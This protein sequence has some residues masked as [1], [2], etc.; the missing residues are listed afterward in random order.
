M[1]D[2]DQNTQ[3][4]VTPN[5][6]PKPKRKKRAKVE[7]DVEAEAPP[8]Q[9]AGKPVELVKQNPGEI[10]ATFIRMY[11]PTLWCLEGEWMAYTAGAYLSITEKTV[12]ARVHKFLAKARQIIVKKDENGN[13][14][15]TTGPFNPKK[16]D[17]NEVMEA[18]TL[19]R[20]L[21]IAQF[22]P[23]CWLSKKDAD[24]NPRPDPRD[25][26]V[27]KNGLLNIR[28]RKLL[29]HTASFFTRTALPIE[30]KEDAP[31]P[32]GWLKFL[33]EVTKKRAGLVT[34]VQE[35]CGYL[36]SSD[37]EQEKVFYMVGKSRGG[38]GTI[39]ESGDR[40]ARPQQ[41]RRSYHPQLLR[42]LLGVGADGQI[43]CD[44]DRYD[45]NGQAGCEDR[46]LQYQHAERARPGGRGSQ[47]PPGTDRNVP[48]NSLRPNR[49]WAPGLW[50]AHDRAGEPLVGHSV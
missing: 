1:S 45:H 30:Y 46:R 8:K 24:G 19:S 12:R 25:I 18:L 26:I 37:A 5:P 36:T 27:C 44:G 48:P 50:R 21:P 9:E 47:V 34:L 49:Q 20:H 10:A 11:A 4:T 28:T 43:G 15:Q 2:E 7:A 35:M 31:L 22:T 33:D 42:R 39:S 40:P 29:P 3:E 32:A 13:E 14:V 6:E 41:R 16:A 23:P 17:T 38:K